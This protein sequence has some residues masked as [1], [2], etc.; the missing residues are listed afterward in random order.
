MRLSICIAVRDDYAGLWATVRDIPRSHPEVSDIEIVVADNNPDSPQGQ[1]CANTMR[2]LPKELHAKYIPAKDA[3]GCSLAKQRAIDAATGD[4]VV[5]M[6]AHVFLAPGSLGK[7]CDV[8][9]EIPNTNDLYGGPLV[10]TGDIC[11]AGQEQPIKN[12]TTHLIEVWRGGDLGTWDHDPRGESIDNE[13]F[14]IPASNTGMLAFRRKA[15][16]GFH[17]DFRGFGTEAFYLARMTRKKGGRNVCLP[18]LRW[19]HRFWAKVRPLKPP[20]IWDRLRN[21]TLGH[22]AT[23]DPLDEMRAHLTAEF[24]VSDDW[25]D[26]LLADPV[27]HIDPPGKSPSLFVQIG[28]ALKRLG[29]DNITSAA[30]G[31]IKPQV[32]AWA[33]A[34]HPDRSRE[35]I[36]RLS[37]APC[38]QRSPGG[39]CRKFGCPN[40]REHLVPCLYLCRMA[41]ADCPGGLFL[42]IHS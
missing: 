14:E 13:P 4:F 26:W 16:A 21:Y 7:L 10:M 17:P 8:F 38:E 28:D 32:T 41:T 15:F 35:D 36:E 22:L 1:D 27:G 19:E 24:K 9:R 39:M 5:L 11:K 25:W 12:I 23:G 37:L 6:D 33:A 2:C 18:F 3:P 30:V 31:A 42:S 20:R 29:I 34:G 40:N